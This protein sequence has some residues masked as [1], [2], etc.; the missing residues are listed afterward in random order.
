[1]R[2]LIAAKHAPDG[3]RKIGGVQSWSR[4]VAAELNS[5]GYEAVTWGPEQPIPHGKFDL[6][7]IANVGNTEP[8]F[9]RCKEIRVVSHGIIPAEK[10]MPG[11]V[12]IFTSEEIRDHWGWEGPVIRQPIDTEFWMPSPWPLHVFLTRFSYRSGLRFVQSLAE[13]LNL[14]YKHLRSSTVEVVRN[15]LWQSAVVLATGR[16]ALEA[17]A[18]GV[19][20]VLCDHRG[21]YQPPLMNLNIKQAMLQNYSGRGGVEPNHENLTEAISQAIDRGSQRDHVLKYHNVRDITDQ[22]LEAA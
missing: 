22:L 3:A 7:I 9:D 20:V 17:M 14:R 15:I 16:A 10:P 21:S 13:S 6:G 4:T 8:V 12:T 5:R 11:L 19:P 1:M 18:C 2:I